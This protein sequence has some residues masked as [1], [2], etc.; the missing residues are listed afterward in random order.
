[1]SDRARFLRPPLSVPSA[2]WR[3][4]LAAGILFLAGL[5]AA[6][7]V[8]SH[9]PAD[10]PAPSIYPPNARPANLLG[11]PGARV[12]HALIDA[13]GAAV[14][15]LLASWFVLVVLLALRRGLLRWSLRLAGWLLLVPIAAVLADRFAFA[16]GQDFLGTTARAGPGGS[17][18]AWLSLWL[19][20]VLPPAGQIVVLAAVLLVGLALAVDVLLWRIAKL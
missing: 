13:L 17:I 2:R 15:V 5:L 6:L 16:S 11:T 19:G 1:M 3:L 18:G 20:R 8:F 14:H 4:D 12:A 7:C 10:P 9:D